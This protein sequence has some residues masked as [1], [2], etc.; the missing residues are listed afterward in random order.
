MI[1]KRKPIIGIMGPGEPADER[2][3][4]TAVELG[5]LIA[6]AGWHLLTGGRNAGVMHAASKGACLAGGTVIGILPGTS[7]QGMSDY[8]TIPV[9]T[10]LGH[11]RN[12]VNILTA[13]AIV[14]CGM[15]LGTASEASLALKNG[16]KV[17]FTMVTES[18][19]AFF[20]R[21]APN[22]CLQADGAPE[23]IAALRKVLP[24][25]S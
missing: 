20:S 5:R 24:E 3:M 25:T 22:S 1:H 14:V 7:H 23:T 21:I 15:G 11:A 9:L 6:E 18:D 8:V 10:G 17:I 2:V 16:K 4:D 19:T 13:D 12:A